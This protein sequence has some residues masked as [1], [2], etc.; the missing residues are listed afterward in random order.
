[1][2]SPIFYAV[3]DNKDTF[4]N[5]PEYDDITAEIPDNDDMLDMLRISD[6]CE[7]YVNDD[8]TWHRGVYTPEDVLETAGLNGLADAKFVDGGTD[9]VEATILKRTLIDQ[10]EDQLKLKMEYVDMQRRFIQQG[11]VVTTDTVSPWGKP[12]EPFT[13]EDMD[14]M[15]R[16]YNAIESIGGLV[17]LPF[18]TSEYTGNL[19]HGELITE[20]NI[21]E[22]LIY[23]MGNRKE[24]TMYIPTNIT[25]DYHF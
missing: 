12:N 21:L 23:Y 9:W 6:W 2:H 5:L 8:D 10:Y 16:Y 22:Q 7:T 25:G 14:L 20:T 1:M 4:T 13:Q 24:L 17:I 18:L 11:I 15:R 19:G 3:I